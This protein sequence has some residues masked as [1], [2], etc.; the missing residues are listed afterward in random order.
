[1]TPASQSP[2]LAWLVNLFGDPDAQHAHAAAALRPLAER[3]GASVVPVYAFDDDAPALEDVAE[4]E[5]HEYTKARLT[6]LLASHDLPPGDPVVVLPGADDSLRERVE[7]L[8]E[9]VAEV[10]PLFVAVHTHSYTTVDRVVLGSFSERFFNHAPCPVLVLN[11]QRDAP[12]AVQAIAFATDFSANAQAAFAQLLPIARALGATVI[13]EHQ[14]AVREL[15]L[16]L[17]GP[18]AREQYER[19]LAEERTRY[20]GQLVPFRV[21]AEAAGVR[22]SATVAVE[23]ASITPGEGV[24]ERAADRGVS[25]IAVCAHGDHRRPGNLGSTA[26][27]LMRHA[28]RPVLVFPAARQKR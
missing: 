25:M 9:A 27:W 13:V 3:L 26:L 18:S 16:F 19:E 21:A 1:M 15:P 12:A 2:R 28:R 22:V 14:L 23:S 11:P 20:E 10:E 4:S 8:A 5:R 24:E 7:R 6:A 17:S